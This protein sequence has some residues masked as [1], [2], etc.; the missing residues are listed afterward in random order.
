MHTF[1]SR[2]CAIHINTN[3]LQNGKHLCLNRLFMFSVVESV[4]FPLYFFL[5]FCFC[6]WL[7][8]EFSTLF[9]EINETS[10][11]KKKLFDKVLFPMRSQKL[12]IYQFRDSWKNN[13]KLRKQKMIDSMN[14]ILI[15]SIFVYKMQLQN[16]S[17]FTST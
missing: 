10:T 13:H 5:W 2:F 14:W 1:K 6:F 17:H 15:L 3:Y 9:D 12:Y 7:H 16:I 8:F 11:I 4:L